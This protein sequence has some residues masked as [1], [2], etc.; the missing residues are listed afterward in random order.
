MTL[1]S[2][3]VAALA[4]EGM[5]LACAESCTGG[6]FGARLT[7]VPGAGDVFRGGLISYQDEMKA[8][9]LHVERE[10]LARL[11]AVSQPVARQMAEGAREA[12]AAD[13]AVSITG[14]AGPSVPPGGELGRVYIGISHW[15]GTEV[16]DLHF[17]ADREKVREGA[18]EE[19]LRFVLDVIPR[20]AK[21]RP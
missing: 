15:G 6:L 19:A 1:E 8:E 17:A 10:L 11:G 5:W 16:H 14:F 18:T 13:I 20:A 2:R 4:K 7:R 21:A 9:F 3:V 12:F